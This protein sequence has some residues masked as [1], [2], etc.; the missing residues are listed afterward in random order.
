MPEL[1]PLRVF[2]CH[3]SQDKPAVR[4]LYSQLKSEAWIDPW[5]DEVKLLPICILLLLV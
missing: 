4:N 5:L 3:A 2:L 1:R